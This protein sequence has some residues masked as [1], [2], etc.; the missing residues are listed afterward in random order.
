MIVQV[1]SC[2]AIISRREIYVYFK[3]LQYFSLLLF[4][5]FFPLFQG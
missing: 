4:E 1:V 3:V 5:V 2:I